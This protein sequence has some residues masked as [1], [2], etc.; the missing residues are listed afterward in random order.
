MKKKPK[1]CGDTLKILGFAFGKR[2]NAKEHLKYIK[3]N[4][5]SKLWIIRHMQNSGASDELLA[6]IYCAYVHPIVEYISVS[7]HAILSG[8]DKEDLENLQRTALSMIYTSRRLSYARALEHSN[9]ETLTSRQKDAVRKFAHKIEMNER[10]RTKWLAENQ[11]K[12][13]LRRQEK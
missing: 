6:K 4:F 12:A 9:L 7:Y 8:G 5:Y 3:R 1:L 2:P 10:F 13:A 11:K